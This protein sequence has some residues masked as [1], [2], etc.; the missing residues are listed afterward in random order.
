MRGYWWAPDGKSLL[1]ARVD[2]EPVQR[3]Y[4]ADP[5]NPEQPATEVRYPAAG[6]P[7]AE[8]SLFLAGLD[9]TLTQVGW[10]QVAF[11]YLV[12]VC[13]EGSGAGREGAVLVGKSPGAGREGPA[14][15]APLIV[16]QSR[17]QREMRVLAVDTQTGGTAVVRADTSR[18]WLEIIPGV[19]PGPPP[20]RSRG[21]WTT[22]APGGC[23]SPPPPTWRR[24][25]PS[26]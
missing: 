1:V 25:R 4:I 12:T 17:D 5:S 6:T 26:R 7:N 13:W 14:A 18:H 2:D 23:W 9:G 8:V 22:E 21:R 3:W 24:G 20:G 15:A 19:R 11:P 10:D 16:V